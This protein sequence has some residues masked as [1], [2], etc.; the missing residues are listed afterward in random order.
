MAT[1]E[2]ETAWLEVARGKLA[3]E[4]EPLVAGARPGDLPDAARSPGVRRH[5]LRFEVEAETY[6]A[7]RQAVVELRRASD[8]SLD[9]DAALLAMARAVLGG[10]RDEGRA[11]YQVSLCVCSECG[12]GT[13]AAGGAIVPVGPSV[14]AMAACDA[15]QVGPITAE[16]PATQAKALPSRVDTLA[17]AGARVGARAKQS[18]PPAL[19]RQVLH[20]D[21]HRCWVPG[22]QHATYVDVHHIRPRAEGGLNTARNLIVLCGMHHRAV[23]VGALI[24]E[25]ASADS[26]RFLHADGTPYGHGPD[27]R[28]LEVHAKVFSALRHLGFRETEAR[29]VLDVL[30]R[31]ASPEPPSTEHLLRAALE[32]IA[33]PRRGR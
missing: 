29:A 20:R 1:P 23:H 26:L 3:R 13:Q 11:S 25:G 21:H 6:A 19:R 14:V 8:A 24:I 16:T 22:C 10:P 15:Q 31:E 2:T 30:Y 17:S 28:A 18:I 33:S 12:R 7:F 9:D 5:V 27:P 4:L 32:R